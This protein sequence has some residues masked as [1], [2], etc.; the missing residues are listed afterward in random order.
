MKPVKLLP[1]NSATVEG[2][3]HLTSAIWILMYVN[4]EWELMGHNIVLI[5]E[6]LTNK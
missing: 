1:L 3:L 4:R 5:P 6:N 2:E